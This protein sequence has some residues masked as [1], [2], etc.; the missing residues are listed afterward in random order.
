MINT[1]PVKQLT[2]ATDA[3][4]QIDIRMPFVNRQRSFEGV[5]LERLRYASVD[6]KPGTRHVTVTD[7]NGTYR[8]TRGSM[9]IETFRKF[10]RELEDT[11]NA[12]GNMYVVFSYETPIAWSQLSGGVY[13]P[14]QGYTQTTARH[15]TVVRCVAGA[16]DT[17]K[18]DATAINTEANS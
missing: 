12:N 11:R 6:S 4:R 14:A 16:T 3:V 5:V 8:L 17:Y 1:K 18:R 13:V 15:Q 10:V 9:S 2:V 7:D